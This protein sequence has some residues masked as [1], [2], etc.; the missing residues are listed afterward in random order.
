MLDLAV[1][2]AKV[3]DVDR[4][5]GN[6][7]GAR[8]GFEE[9]K[10]LVEGMGEGETAG[11]EQRVSFGIVGVGLGWGGWG[12]WGGRKLSM[13]HNWWI[14]FAHWMHTFEQ[15]GFVAPFWLPAFTK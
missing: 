14:D 6:E 11:L 12:G 2:L 13:G 7:A 5:L 3:A 4:A 1:S 8:E 10:E 15:S 9:A